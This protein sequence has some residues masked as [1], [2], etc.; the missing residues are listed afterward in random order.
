MATSNRVQVTSVAETTLGTTPTTPRMRL[1]RL[2]GESLSYI[3]TFDMA[4]ELRS[5]RMNTDPIL[6]GTNSGG[7]INFSL[8][9]PM[10][11]T[12]LDTD[13]CSAMNSTWSQ[14]NSRDNDGTADSIITD[15]ATL[16]T[17]L[18]VTTGTAFVAKELYRFTGFG[19]TGNNG[20]FACTTGSATV[21]RFV[22]SG[23]TN[24][25]A[26]PAAA[27]VKNVGFIGDSGDI[28][29]TATGLSSTTTNFTTFTGLTVGKWIKIGGT[30]AAYRFVTSALNAYVRVTAISATAL[31]LDNLPSGWTTETGTGLTV[32]VWYGDQIINGTT[33]LG[34]TIERGH[35][36]QTTPTY[37]VQTGMV[38]SQFSLSFKAKSKITGS[39]SY[40]GMSGSQSTT[41]LDAS[42]D[43]APTIAS[44][45][46]FACSANVGRVTEGGSTIASPNFV[47]SMDITIN[48]NVTPVDAIDSTGPAG[49]TSQECL[50]SGTITPYF[51][52]N[53]LLTKLFAGTATSISA[54]ATK[55][56]QCQIWTLPRVTYSSQ[57]SPNAT[58]KNQDVMLPLGFSASK[59]ET[60]TNAQICWDRLEYI[61]A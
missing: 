43:A 35:M 15:V 6:T 40:V 26:P 24:E 52:D 37:I 31:T 32:K 54:R 45:P 25:T 39:V 59:D 36:G 34:Q 49:I 14:T 16:N 50:V 22:G 10:P 60:T 29:A 13:I 47:N 48:N 44:Y 17:V 42:P 12:P 5:D 41:S 11:N 58:A 7:A 8:I 18:T 19:V 4:A 61:E 38:C 28:N 27:R 30:G 53:S 46:I 20:V 57:G 2:D 1:R 51:G 23:I 33:Q 56:S 3:P 21:P 55:G 9:Y